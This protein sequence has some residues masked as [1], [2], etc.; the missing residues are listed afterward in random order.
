VLHRYRGWRS[1]RVCARLLKPQRFGVRALALGALFG[2]LVIV[3]LADLMLPVM[4]FDSTMYHMRAARHYLETASVSYDATI[5][6]NAHPHL[7]VLLYMRHWAALGEHGLVKLANIEFLLM[8][9]LVLVY[10]ARELRWKDGWTAGLMFVMSSPLFLFVAH[11]EYADLALAA[12]F[13]VAAALL[14]HHLRHGGRAALVAGGLVLGFAGAVK[15]QGLVLAAC[16]VAGFAV[17][18]L[19]ARRGLAALARALAAIGALIVLSGAGWWLRSWVNT[20]SPAFPFF[21]GSHPDAVAT[22]VI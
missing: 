20:G 5:R 9:V 8:L 12:Y 16:G 21:A 17:A 22:F 13:A 19:Y 18:W 7:S 4:E 6:Y 2:F 15:L 3:L 11:L 14:F 10:A 1:L